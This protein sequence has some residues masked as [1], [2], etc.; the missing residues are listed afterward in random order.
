MDEELQAIRQARLAQLQ[1]E[2]GS[3]PSNIASGPSS[4]Q[5]QQ[6][7]QDEMRQNLL[8][9]ILEHPARDR[10]RRIAL[11]RK[12]RAE[13]VEELLLR[14]AKTGQISHKISEPELIELLEKISGEVSK[15]NETKIVIN[16]RV[17]DDED[18]WDL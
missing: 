7:V 13:A 17:Q 18:D 2:H 11:V 16:R 12:D 1:A 8:S 10:L 15:R 6:E 5:Q 9:Q 3:A 14:M 4:N